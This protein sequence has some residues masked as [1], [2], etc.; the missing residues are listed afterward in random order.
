MSWLAQLGDAM[1]E[2]LA[3]ILFAI[4]LLQMAYLGMLQLAGLPI[5]FSVWPMGEDR[6]WLRFMQ[7][8]P[9]LSMMHEF[10]AM[11]DRNPLSPWWYWLFRWPIY[12][13]DYGLFVVRK[14]VAPTLAIVVTLLLGRRP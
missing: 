12:H 8:G 4:W 7:D 2:H 1:I 5:G 9:G 14:L 3:I 13:T 6:N 11:N 10:W